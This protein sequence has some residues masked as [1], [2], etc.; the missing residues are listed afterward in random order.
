MPHAHFP[1]DVRE[2][3]TCEAADGL[4]RNDPGP[5]RRIV[6]ATHVVEQLLAPPG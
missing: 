4:G 5:L 6:F 1:G 2:A 3:R